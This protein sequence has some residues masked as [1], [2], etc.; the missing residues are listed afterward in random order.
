MK[1]MTATPNHAQLTALCLNGVNGPTAPRVV[2]WDSA[3]DHV[4]SLS[5][6]NS[7]ELLVVCQLN[8][9]HATCNHAQLTALCPIGP[10]GAL[11]LN[12]VELDQPPEPEKSLLNL[13]STERH[14]EQQLKPSTATLNHAQ[15][16]VS[17]LNGPH[18]HHVTK[19]AEEDLNLE[20]ELSPDLLNSVVSFAALN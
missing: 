3:H 12:P 16:T 6:T 20:P 8:G 19:H 11:A 2:V 1:E 18:S 7:E 14:A 15:L 9:K 10:F 4:I 17:F 13:N 5:R